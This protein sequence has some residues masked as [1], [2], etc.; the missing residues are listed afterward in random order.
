MAQLRDEESGDLLGGEVEAIRRIGRCE[1]IVGALNRLL[2]SRL[3]SYYFA[4]IVVLGIV[5]VVWTALKPFPGSPQF[6]AVEIF[7]N[8][9][10]IFEVAIRLV[11]MGPS[12]FFS[13]WSSR[14]DLIVALL[15]CVALVTYCVNYNRTISEVDNKE[16][17]FILA[18]LSV[19]QI[20]RLGI[21]IVNQHQRRMVASRVITFDRF[22][23]SRSTD[24]FELLSAQGAYETDED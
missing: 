4:V 15:S 18:L 21:M 24:G 13:T 10:M 19:A 1:R 23:R 22:R 20:T 17:V 8:C 6:L 3:Y 5:T 11:A 9:A 14:F 12:L 7:V 2:H 16:E